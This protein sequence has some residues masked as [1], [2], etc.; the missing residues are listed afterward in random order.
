MDVK[1]WTYIVVGLSFALYIGIA[2]WSRASSTK[3]FYVAG[4]SVSPISNGMATAADWMSAASFISMAGMIAFAG[5]G[6]SVFLMGWTGGYVLLA[7]MLAPYMRKYGKFTVPEF[8][9]ERFYSKTARIVAVICLIIVSVTYV[10][11]QMKGVGVAFSRFLETDYNT[12][13]YVGMG[14][15]F[16]YAVLGGMKGITYTQIAQYVVLIFAYTVPAVF[17]SLKLTGNPIPQ[18][19]LGGSVDGTPLLEK[20]DK[21]IQDL[22]FNEYTTSVNGNKLNMFVYTLTLMI[23][24]AGLPHVIIR[25]FTVPK[26]SDARLSAG[27]ALVFIAI[28]YTTAPAVAAMARLN[29]TETIQTGSVGEA[30]GNLEYEKRPE[31]FKNWEKTELLKHNDWNKDGR[32]QYYGDKGLGI[33]K[34]N[35]ELANNKLAKL[36]ENDSALPAEVEE[37]EQAITK[38]NEEV[39]TAAAKHANTRFEKF[40]WQGNEM[41]KIDN[42]IIV[43]ANPEIAKLPGW[44]I[45]LVVAG[46]LA[47]ALSTAAGLLLAISSAVSHDLLKGIFRP[48]ISEKQELNASRLAMVGAIAVAGYFGLNPPDFAAGTVAIAF[49]LAASSIFPV[50]MMGIFSKRMNRQGAVAG[51]VAGMSVTLI[52]VFQHK[53]ILFISSTSFLGGM[54]PNWFLGITPNAFGAIGALVNFAVAFAVS[55]TAPEAPQE[56]QDLVESIRVPSRD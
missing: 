31:W 20:L 33:A 46:G 32:I 16:F 11:G 55:K 45:A 8:I 44:V 3:E 27:W 34:N 4:G 29:L 21:V 40:G 22:G 6:G 7:L 38:A 39:Q 5:Y 1:T 48:S 54:E 56:V 18:L 9:G 35:L 53:G 36:K 52:Y 25:F 24:T 41:T 15:V 42:D 26:V 23:G 2:I 17:I 43:L 50:L 37:A 47:A 12:G 10:I 14:I 13:L 19:G 28:L 51:M 49:G 30:T